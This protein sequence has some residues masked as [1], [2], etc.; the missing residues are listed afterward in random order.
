MKT[1]GEARGGPGAVNQEGWGGVVEVTEEV[2][3]GPARSARRRRKAPFKWGGDAAG[4]ASTSLALHV[5]HNRAL[6]RG[7]Q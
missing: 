4:S 3:E 6:S 2:E 1:G 7:G 5:E